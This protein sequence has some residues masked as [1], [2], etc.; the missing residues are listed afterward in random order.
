[1]VRCNAVVILSVIVWHVHAQ[2]EETGR[3]YGKIQ[4]PVTTDG[5]TGFETVPC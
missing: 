4:R 5:L 1:M 2:A 3:V